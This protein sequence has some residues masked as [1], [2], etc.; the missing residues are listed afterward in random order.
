MAINTEHQTQHDD[1]VVIASDGLFDNMD[2]NQIIDV[3]APFT[4]DTAN[5]VDPNHI[6]DLIAQA[7][8]KYSLDRYGA[9]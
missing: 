6:A 4:K 1:I 9:V 7:A 8:Y 5:L 2:E 3:I